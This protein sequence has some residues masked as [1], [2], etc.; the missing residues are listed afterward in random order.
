MLDQVIYAMSRNYDEWKKI[1][2]GK[3]LHI[4]YQ[5]KEQLILMI[6]CLLSLKIK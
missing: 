1:F 5:W 6:K 4:F 3:V 2:S